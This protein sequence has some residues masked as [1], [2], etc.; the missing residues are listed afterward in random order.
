MLGVGTLNILDGGVVSNDS[1]VIGD[2]DS[3]FALT[4]VVTVSGTGSKWT[5]SS[6]LWVGDEGNGTLNITEGSTVS[7]VNGHVAAETGSTGTNSGDLHVGQS[8]SG[9]LNITDSGEV[10]V[11]GITWLYANGTVNIDGGAMSVGETLQLDA[12]STVNLNSGTMSLIG[13]SGDDNLA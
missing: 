2:F 13:F 8:G 10:H 7:N 9:T 11:G 5:N 1:G 6:D 3:G 12:G 4:N